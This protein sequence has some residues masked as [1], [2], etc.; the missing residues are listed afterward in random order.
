MCSPCMV[1]KRADCCY[2]AAGDQRRTSALKQRIR[3]LTRQTG[4]LKAVIAGIGTA[5]D[6]DAATAIA[7][8]LDTDDFDALADVAQAFRRDKVAADIFKDMRKDA[9]RGNRC[10]AANWAMSQLSPASAAVADIQDLDCD[11]GEDLTL[12]PLDMAVNNG[13]LAKTHYGNPEYQVRVTTFVIVGPREPKLCTVISWAS[14]T[15]AALTFATATA[16]TTSQTLAHPWLGNFLP[17]EMVRQ[18]FCDSVQQPSQNHRGVN[19]S[20]KLQSRFCCSHA[21][22]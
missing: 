14:W 1:K 16:T 9:S 3:D 12:W 2:D 15:D 19:A 7:R 8:Q 5:V 20:R 18:R 21:L 13:G 6:K 4:D 22:Y 10:D 17:G 11:D